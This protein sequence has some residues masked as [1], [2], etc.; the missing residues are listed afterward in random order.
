MLLKLATDLSFFNEYSHIY[1][2]LS[3]LPVCLLQLDELYLMVQ[4][5]FR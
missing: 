1:L 5:D 3:S 4:A 2:C